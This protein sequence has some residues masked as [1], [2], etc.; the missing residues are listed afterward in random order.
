MELIL[1]LVVL[2]EPAFILSI[3]QQ[4]HLL[5]QLPAVLQLQNTAIKLYPVNREVL[6]S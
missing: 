4:R 3:A 5:L 1:I 2:V 6:T